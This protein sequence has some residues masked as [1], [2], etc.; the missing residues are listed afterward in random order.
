M[1]E[2]NQTVYSS[3][4][5]PLFSPDSLLVFPKLWIS[6]PAKLPLPLTL[7]P[8]VIPKSL[9]FYR[10]LQTFSSRPLEE[11][12]NQFTLKYLIT[13]QTCFHGTQEMFPKYLICSHCKYCID[14]KHHQ[15]LHR[16]CG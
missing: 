9:L 13:I 14:Y 15:Q 1:K 16:V 2:Q 6:C 5:C 7:D 4:L 12:I 11:N 8:S 10:K 3:S